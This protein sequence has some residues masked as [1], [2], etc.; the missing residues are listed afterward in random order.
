MGFL[1]L[2]IQKCYYIVHYTL[3]VIPSHYEFIHTGE[4][5]E[6]WHPRWNVRLVL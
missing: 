6:G 1:T 3:E 5:Y 4:K 2:I